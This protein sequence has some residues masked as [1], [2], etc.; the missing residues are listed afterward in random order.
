MAQRPR[1]TA[2]LGRLAAVQIDEN[3]P[4][5][6]FFRS[7]DLVIKQARVYKMEHDYEQAYILYMKYTT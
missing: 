7:A 4:I 1:S 6:L 3:T 5:R 2:E